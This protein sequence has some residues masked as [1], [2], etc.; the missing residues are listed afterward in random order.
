VAIEYNEFN[1]ESAYVY[2]IPRAL[3]RALMS[4]SKV[5]LDT[6]D[7]IIIDAIVKGKDVQIDKERIF[8][9]KRPSMASLWPGWGSPML[10]PVLKDV[11]YYYILRKANEALALQRIVPLMVLFPQ[12]NADVTPFQHL[13]LSS[14]KSRVED[15]L[16][17]WRKDPN[18]VPIMPIPIGNQIIGGD[19]R[20]MMVTQEQELVAKGIAAGLGVPIEFI[21]GGLSWSG[22]SVSLRILENHFLKLRNQDL[23]FINNHLIPKLARIYRIPKIKVDFTKFKMADDVQAK[24]QA[25]NLMQ[26]GYLSRK[27]VLEED[28]YDGEEEVNQMEKEHIALNR[29]KNSDQIAEQEIRN[30]LKMMDTRNSVLAQYEAQDVQQEMEEARKMDDKE[31]MKVKMEDLAE[32]YALSLSAMDPTMA[33]ATLDKMK[34]EMPNLFNLVMSKMRSLSPFS[35]LPNQEPQA[36]PPPQEGVAAPPTP[37][38]SAETKMDVKGPNIGDG[39]GSLDKGEPALEHGMPRRESGGV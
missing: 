39:G 15:E 33:K 1:G 22:S 24:S 3:R 2:K 30:T 6:L 21:Q 31:E 7:K 14:W 32:K 4:S 35:N 11:H 19:A 26:S 34:G 12:A 37:A 38:P 8:H 18:H 23:N 20:Q 36:N 28:G 29:V 17:R 9:L 16:A 25:Y 27:T 5:V 13:N 10:V